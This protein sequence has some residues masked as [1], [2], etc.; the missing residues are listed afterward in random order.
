MQN[1]EVYSEGRSVE[2]IPRVLPSKG[3]RGK[4]KGSVQAKAYPIR[5]FKTRLKRVKKGRK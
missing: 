1:P 2:E 5:A 3:I 4:N